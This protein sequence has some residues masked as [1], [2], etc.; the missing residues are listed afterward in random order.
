MGVEYIG[1]GSRDRRAGGSGREGGGK[2]MKGAQ[3]TTTY[4]ETAS[5][6]LSPVWS[7]M[8]VRQS[9]LNSKPLSLGNSHS[10]NR[11]IYWRLLHMC[12]HVRAK[13]T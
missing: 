13:F 8:L 11:L 5:M 7:I 2:L 10:R 3:T 4:Q 9:T 12:M 1:S 6:I